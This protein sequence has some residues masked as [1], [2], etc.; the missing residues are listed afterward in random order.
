M[1]DGGTACKISLFRA[2]CKRKTARSTPNTV[3]CE[4]ES[5]LPCRS[6]RHL[7]AILQSIDDHVRHDHFS[8][9]ARNANIRATAFLSQCGRT[10][11]YVI[12][13]LAYSKKS[14]YS[15][16]A[17]LQFQILGLCCKA[18]W[19]KGICFAISLILSAVTC[20]VLFLLIR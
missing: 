17:R 4:F 9:A 15:R 6:R 20:T 1:T 13:R 2:I 5:I 16:L 14:Q 18:F 11:V 10:V 19:K 12:R 7:S 8:S 3:Y